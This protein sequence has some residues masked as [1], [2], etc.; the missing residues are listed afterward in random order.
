MTTNALGKVIA[1]MRGSVHGFQGA[2]FCIHASEVLA[3]ADQLAAVRVEGASEN[4]GLREALSIALQHVPIEG[5]DADRIHVLVK[6]HCSDYTPQPPAPSG[7]M[8]VLAEAITCLKNCNEELNATGR[9][10]HRIVQAIDGLQNLAA[11]QS[12]DAGAV[13]DDQNLYDALRWFRDMADRCNVPTIHA[14]ILKAINAPAIAVDEAA[15]CDC[16][17][18][19]C[20]GQVRDSRC[21]LKATFGGFE[22]FDAAN[23]AYEVSKRI[24]GDS[25]KRALLNACRAY[26]AALTGEKK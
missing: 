6:Q 15:G 5:E 9:Q 11:T 12:Q 14:T 22:P 13:A 24:G 26:T 2:G 8:A 19:Q 21:N 18:T 17:P 3:W 1:E 16:E 23:N 25:H 20:H 10:S 4:E 7:L